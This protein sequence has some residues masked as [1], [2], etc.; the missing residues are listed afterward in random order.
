MKYRGKQYEEAI[1]GLRN[2]RAHYKITKLQTDKNA[3]HAEMKRIAKKFSISVKTVYRDMKK[4]IPGLRK[5]RSDQGKLKTKL[6]AATVEKANEL[7]KAGKTKKEAQT[8]LNISQRKMK[9]LNEKNKSAAF[10]HSEVSKYGGEAKEFFKKLFDY[11]LIAPDRGIGLHYKGTSFIVPKSDL[12]DIILILTNAYNS[13]IFADEKKL[14]FD[15]TELRS[16]MMQHLIEEQ[17]RLAKESADYK[18]VEAL[19][20]MIDRLKEDAALSDDF[21]TIVKVCQTLK[22]DISTTDVIA[23]IKK[24]S[25]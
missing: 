1:I 25:E 4:K 13:K 10:E 15:R 5:T 24:V 20:R 19:T 17:M 16:A 9:R 18:L 7:M 23:L 2:I 11:D 8:V 22:P 6:S 21:E 14:P 3:Y 12:N